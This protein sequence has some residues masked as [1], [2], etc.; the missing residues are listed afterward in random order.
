MGCVEDLLHERLRL[1]ANVL[2]MQL[3]LTAL[4][5]AAEELWS[6]TDVPE[7]CEDVHGGCRGRWVGVVC[8]AALGRSIP[9]CFAAAQLKLPICASVCQCFRFHCRPPASRRRVR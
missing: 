4:N 1:C 6:R 8:Y 7:L 3:R 5:R 9:I 2:L